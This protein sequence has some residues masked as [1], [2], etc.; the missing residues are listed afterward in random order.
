MAK[1]K[2][3]NV[4]TEERETCCTF[5]YATKQW[6][7]WS[8]IPKHINKMKKLGWAMVRE[9]SY[10][11]T[12]AAPENAMRF[13]SPVRSTRKMTDEQKAAAAER[14]RLAR[15]GRVNMIPDEDEET[16]DDED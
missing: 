8:N 10:G 14:L 15:M 5:D 11:T 7:V 13:A 12:F 6:K 4:H 9:D 3:I 16:I 1:E 2:C